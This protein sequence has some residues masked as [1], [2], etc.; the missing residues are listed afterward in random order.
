MSKVKKPKTD[1][2]TP[3][4]VAEA[5]TLAIG[6]AA[7]HPDNY[8]KIFTF[9][10]R[11]ELF[12]VM[13][14]PRTVNTVLLHGDAKKRIDDL[15][16]AQIPDW[17]TRN[18]APTILHEILEY[19]DNTDEYLEISIKVKLWGL[20]VALNYNGPTFYREAMEYNK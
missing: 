18:S 14:N 16:K 7:D 15:H 1:L 3:K 5:L 6:A 9:V 13:G 19:A 20:S 12:E 2:M 4:H 11:Q 8:G 17:L 10:L